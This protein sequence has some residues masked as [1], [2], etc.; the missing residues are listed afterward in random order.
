MELIRCIRWWY[1]P[2]WMRCLS[3]HFWK[4]VFSKQSRDWWTLV[5]S[6]PIRT[7]NRNE[8]KQRWWWW[9]FIALDE[10]NGVCS[11][12]HQTGQEI[13]WE[14]TTR[15]GRWAA[16]HFFNERGADCCTVNGRDCLPPSACRWRVQRYV[17]VH[18]HLFFF[19]FLFDLRPVCHSRRRKK[20]P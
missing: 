14:T 4:K 19:L 16:T 3:F 9:W 8:K 12:Y 7:W 5:S 17:I 11:S 18:A 13:Q 1:I 6:G 15:D 20:K 10:K 2:P